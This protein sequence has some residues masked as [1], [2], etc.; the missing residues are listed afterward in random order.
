MLVEV[1]GDDVVGVRGDPDDPGTAGYTCAKGRAGPAFHRA[2]DRLDVPLVRRAGA[3]VP[4][5]W[6]AVLDD[7]AD[8]TR[9]IVD[10]QGP[11]A[12]ANYVGTGGPLDPAG[13]AVAAGFFR[14]LGS[15]ENYSALSV[16]CS[17]KVLIPQL[18]SG[19]QMM[20]APDLERTSLLI[21]LG[22]N[23]VVSH[24]H[25]VMISNPLVRVRELRA[26]GA[27]LVVVDPRVSETAHHADLHIAPRPATDPALLAHLVRSVLER[28]AD[29]TYLDACADAGSVERLRIAVEPFDRAR[30]AA[31][32][33]VPAE[34]LEELVAMVHVAGRVAI[35]T[36]T[37]TTMNRS[38]NLTEWLAWALAAVT[39]SLDRAGG[40]TFNPGFLRP[41]EDGLPS[42]RGDLEPGPRSRPDLPRIVNG[43]MP[44][45][46]LVDE[47]DAGNVRALF[48]RVGNPAVALPDTPRLRKVFEKLDLLVAIDV[49]SNET[50][51][52]ATHV[53]PMTD[54]FERSDLLTG[55]LQAKPFVRFA[56]AVVSPVGERRQQW[57]M[58][59]ELSRRL[60]LPL[61]GSTRRDAAL[62]NR[63]L[64]DEVISASLFSHSRHPWDDVR[65]A[66]Y[67]IV[68][69]PLPTG[70]MIPD[71]LPRRLDLAPVELVADLASARLES[72]RDTLVLINRRT[73]GRYNSLAISTLDAPLLMHPIDAGERGLADGDTATVAT[74]TGSCCAVVRV[75]D[76]IRPGVVSLPHAVASADVNRLTATTEFDHRNGMPVLSGFPVTVS[77]G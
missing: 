20:F 63:V 75:T 33:G 3:L 2:P 7:I 61:F 71:R 39:G 15:G 55:Y 21:A 26:R 37:G 34:Q 23:T 67:G 42:G 51:A 29:T 14:A 62:A 70:W 65:A 5:T 22:V 45:A 49:R 11:S 68:D 76:L 72:N 17:G 54:H 27:K 40:V 74:P 18:V 53:L 32:C 10:E 77:A 48:V 16:D 56:P 12:I 47:I 59:A 9:A 58:F 30:T 64:D 43:E 31:I 52:L 38:A 1:D 4:S 35:E 25:G 69:D 13:Y 19:V 8:I 44:C 60:G 41:F 57:W 6:E 46:A 28:G 36:G 73:V 66:P 24:G 50:T